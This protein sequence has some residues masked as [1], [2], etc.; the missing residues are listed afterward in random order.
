MNKFQ[1]FLK[2]VL[3]P[4]LGNDV[5]DGTET[6][7]EATAKLESLDPNLNNSTEAIESLQNS[8]TELSA[9]VETLQ[10]TLSTISTELNSLTTRLEAVEQSSDITEVRNS[11][12]TLTSAVAKLATPKNEG[13]AGGIEIPDNKEPKGITTYESINIGL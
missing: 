7:D 12:A 11:L 2:N 13:A 1:T 8:F 9:T 4:I 3:N 6:E 10:T 5:F